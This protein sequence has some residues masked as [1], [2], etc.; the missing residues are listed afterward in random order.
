MF[1]RL[2]CRMVSSIKCER[3]ATAV[4]YGIMVALIAFVIML[5]VAALGTQLAGVFNT[6]TNAIGPGTQVQPTP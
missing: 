5:T 1:L 3:G 2:Y 6:V 4:E